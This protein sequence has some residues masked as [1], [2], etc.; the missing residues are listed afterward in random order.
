MYEKYFSQKRLKKEKLLEY[1]FSY[2]KNKR[3]YFYKEKILNINMYLL[4]FFKDQEEVEIKIQVIDINTNEEY[5]L[6]KL[7]NS[8]GQFVSKLRERIQ[9]TLNDIKNKCFDEEDNQKNQ[10]IKYIKE[11]YGTENEYLWK[12]SPTSSIV[13]RKD[14]QK[15]YAVFMNISKRKLGLEFEENIDIVNIRVENTN[16]ENLLNKKG[17]FPAY[18][19]NKKNWISI[20][21]DGEI[22]NDEIFLKI[23]KSY[24]LVETK[25]RKIK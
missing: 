17:Y 14:N 22:K 2:D 13:R 21:L 15:W 7:S 3:E 4:I 9:K 18:H 8:S 1:G 6:Y 25:N 19:M 5:I 12:K 20:C 24:D 10:I 23:D 16:I 11:K